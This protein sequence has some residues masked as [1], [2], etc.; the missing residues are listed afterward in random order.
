MIA[1]RPAETGL[2]SQVPGSSIYLT[3]SQWFPLISVD[4]LNY[5]CFPSYFLRVRNYTVSSVSQKKE[6]VLQNVCQS[7]FLASRVTLEAFSDDK[8][9]MRGTLFSLRTGFRYASPAQE[10]KKSLHLF[11]HHLLIQ[12]I[13]TYFV[14]CIA[15]DPEIV[16]LMDVRV[17]AFVSWGRHMCKFMSTCCQDGTLITRINGSRH[18]LLSMVARAVVLSAEL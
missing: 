5:C 15:L 16:T 7:V 1:Y 8:H 11:I 4:C 17:S 10:K 9:L 2:V 12:Q 6:R 18:V 14:L 3:L 13:S